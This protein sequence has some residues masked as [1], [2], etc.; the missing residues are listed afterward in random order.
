DPPGRQVV[1]P[2]DAGLA[3]SVVNAVYAAVER[4][5]QWFSFPAPAGQAVDE[6]YFRPLR[7]LRVGPETEIFLG[8]VDD[9]DGL[10]RSL[11][12]ASLARAHLADFGVCTVCGLGR[13]RRSAIEPLLELHRDLVDRLAPARS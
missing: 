9:A 8:L 6:E 5:V 10:D 3:V 12:R 11:R 4:P 1:V 13:R 7:D 2:D